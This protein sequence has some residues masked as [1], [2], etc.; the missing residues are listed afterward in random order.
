M[1]DRQAELLEGVQT[2]FDEVLP[3]AKR[4][5]RLEDEL[6]DIGVG[7]IHA[8]EMAGVLEERY[9]VTFPQADLIVLSTVGDFTELLEKLLVEAE[10]TPEK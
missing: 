10:A 9:G 7:S 1:S 5:L 6:V 3:E 2:A 4:R 8:L